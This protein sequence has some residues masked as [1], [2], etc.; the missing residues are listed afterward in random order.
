M[1]L[2]LREVYML[3]P[4]AYIDTVEMIPWEWYTWIHNSCHAAS[5]RF[6]DEASE[7]C[8]GR[9]WLRMCWLFT[10]LSC[11]TSLIA[12]TKLLLP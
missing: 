7:H 4:I 3:R 1:Q 9:L 12:L 6:G 5:P 2:T 8:A 10:P 11:C